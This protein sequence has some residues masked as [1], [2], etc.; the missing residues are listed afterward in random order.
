MSFNRRDDEDRVHHTRIPGKKQENLCAV[1]LPFISG[2]SRKSR[3]NK[4]NE[5]LLFVY[6]NFTWLLHLDTGQSRQQNDFKNDGPRIRCGMRGPSE[7]GQSLVPSYLRRVLL[8]ALAG[9]FALVRVARAFWEF[10]QGDQ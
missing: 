6:M 3:R 9:P 10:G 2:E 5:K 1:Y 7:Q 4:K 8:L